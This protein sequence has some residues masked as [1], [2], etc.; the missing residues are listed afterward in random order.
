[1]TQDPYAG[2]ADL[3]D[4]DYGEF[5]ADLAMYENFARRCELPILEIGVGTGRV[6][7]HLAR[8]GFAVWG[9][10]SSQSMLDRAQAKSDESLSER[11]HLAGADMRDFDLG[12]QFDL[13]ISAASSFAHLLTT[14]DQLQCLAS[15]H[16][17]L[18]EG[19]LFVIA[20]RSLTAID[21]SAASIPAVLEWVR[22]DPA[23]GDTVTKLLSMAYDGARQALHQ[24]HVYDRTAPT[25]RLR[26]RRV[27]EFDLRLVG[28]YE[29][30]HLL[31]CSGLE[32]TQLYGDYEMGPYSAESE[33][34]VVVARRPKKEREC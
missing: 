11:L 18:A 8:A 34:M 4:L 32:L 31:R 2:L 25:G 5:T 29:M 16:R 30:E 27:V 6:A 13:V 17:H 14:E 33:T 3:Y 12:R 21:W 9:I 7:L 24:T 23:S 20:L 26:Q 15:V 22:T 28:R 10:D 1:M 19:G